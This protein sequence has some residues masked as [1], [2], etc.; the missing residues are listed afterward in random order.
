MFNWKKE[1]TGKQY[2]HLEIP[3]H[4]YD[5]IRALTLECPVEISGFGTTSER[6]ENGENIIKVES[7]EIYPQ[8]CS[9]ASTV[10]DDES[11]T[12][13]YLAM[14][15]KEETLNFWWHS[16]VNFGVFFSG[17]DTDTLEKLSEDGGRCVG[18]CTNKKGCK[19]AT[20]YEDGEESNEEIPVVILGDISEETM[21]RAKVNIENNV[22]IEPERK[23]KKKKKY[24]YSYG[25]WYD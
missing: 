12:N 19:V 3:K 2:K 1:P 18:L 23:Y 7:L 5:Y 11:L 22:V 15:E 10:L 24:G 17:T 13:A 16:H 20:I 6:V 9:A 25:N 8:E 21:Q 14:Q 4:I